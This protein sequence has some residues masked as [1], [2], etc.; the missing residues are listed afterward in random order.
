M[1]CSR[2]LPVAKNLWIRGEGSVKIFRREISFSQCRK[3]SSRKPSVFHKVSG[4]EKI[5]D[6]REG[7]GKQYHDILLNIF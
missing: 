5:M 6:K 4:T 7:G 3:T 1:L 2:N